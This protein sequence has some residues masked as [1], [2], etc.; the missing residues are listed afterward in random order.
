MKKPRI[1]DYT[2]QVSAISWHSYI[3]S[4]NMALL[5][6]PT[7]VGFVRVTTWLATERRHDITELHFVHDGK[8]HTRMIRGQRYSERYCVT[9]A[10]RFAHEIGG[11]RENQATP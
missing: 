3:E 10:R 9:L 1:S 11:V 6:V 4:G 2:K 7:K 8:M 5:V